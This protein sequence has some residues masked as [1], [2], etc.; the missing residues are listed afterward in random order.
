M[1]TAGLRSEYYN[2]GQLIQDIKVGTGYVVLPHGMSDKHPENEAVDRW[3]SN[4][5]V[6]LTKL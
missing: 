2:S 6:Y 4:A 5:W 3:N 1:A